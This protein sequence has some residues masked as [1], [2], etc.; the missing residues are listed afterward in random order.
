[1][2]SVERTIHDFGTN[3]ED[4]VATILSQLEIE[5]AMKGVVTVVI[6]SIISIILGTV[7]VVIA[8]ISMSS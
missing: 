6:L 3:P 2:A 4:I 5:M 1:M 7:S 8:I